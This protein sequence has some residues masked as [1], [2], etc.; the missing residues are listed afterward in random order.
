M[1]DYYG[2]GIENEIGKGA[3]L[4]IPRP[5]SGSHCNNP[6]EEGQEPEQVWRDEES[7]EKRGNKRHG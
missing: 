5:I 2:T 3:I 4:E 1:E 7:R 6:C